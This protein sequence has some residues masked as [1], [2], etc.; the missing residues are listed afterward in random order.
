MDPLRRVFKFIFNSSIDNTPSWFWLDILYGEIDSDPFNSRTS[1]AF[2]WLL[3][4]LILQDIPIL[5]L[6]ITL[7][8]STFLLPES[9][10]LSLLSLYLL[11]WS[12]PPRADPRCVSQ[13]RRWGLLRSLLSLTIFLDFHSQGDYRKISFKTKRTLRRFVRS[14]WYSPK[15]RQLGYPCRIY[16]GIHLL[17]FPVLSL[18]LFSIVYLSTFLMKSRF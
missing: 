16:S 13:R 2:F 14:I 15:R 1:A 10:R 7:G 18:T 17:L 4:I 8:F 6:I 12:P 9:V 3:L 5:K 11:L